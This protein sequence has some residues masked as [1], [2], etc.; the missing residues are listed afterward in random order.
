[1]IDGDL[2]NRCR[3]QTEF[4]AVH[5]TS[6]Q[7]ARQQVGMHKALAALVLCIC[8]QAL[9]DELLESLINDNIPIYTEQEKY[10]QCV[11]SVLDRVDAQL[12]GT[13]VPGAPAFM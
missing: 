13:P 6:Q 10:N 7:D 8:L 12:K 1:M 3:L 9:G 5:V 11:L 4:R 2:D